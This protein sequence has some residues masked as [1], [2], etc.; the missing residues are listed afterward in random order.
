MKS[1]RYTR[2]QLI[3][4]RSSPHMLA[5][6]I[7]LISLTFKDFLPLRD[8]CRGLGYRVTIG[9]FA[10]YLSCRLSKQILLCLVLLF[11]D[12]PFINELSP[13][14]FYR[15]K[16]TS[17]FW[18][19][20]LY[21]VVA[22]ILY[23]LT[24]FLLSYLVLFPY[25]TFKGEWGKVLRTLVSSRRF[26]EFPVAWLAF[27]ENTLNRLTVYQA[28][29][30]AISMTLVQSV[31][32]AGSMQAI[33]LA[34]PKSRMS[35]TIFGMAYILAPDIV[36]AFG[37]KSDLKYIPASWMQLT[38]LNLNHLPE[39]PT[40]TISKAMLILF[41]LAILA[42]LIAYFFW[43]EADVYDYIGDLR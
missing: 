30:A 15:G 34:R 11:S 19:N 29:I 10:I 13:Y 25:V 3:S 16:R 5:L 38:H 41:V 42:L 32:L 6:L 4:W 43:R 26:S 35:H 37:V 2:N 21:I 17:Y 39:A 27:Q 28:L 9:Y 22:S 8:A 40:P 24:L 31:F 20:V 36:K 1:F 12:A 14:E 33:A 23:V 18:G 7:F